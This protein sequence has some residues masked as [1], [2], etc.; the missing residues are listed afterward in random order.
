MNSLKEQILKYVKLRYPEEVTGIEIENFARYKGYTGEPGRRRL[1]EL[2][3]HNKLIEAINKTILK[4]SG[5]RIRITNYRYRE[6]ILAFN[7]KPPEEPNNQDSLP[8][9]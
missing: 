5:R 1:R 4:S 3:G 8:S 9:I 6:P 2:T 7:P